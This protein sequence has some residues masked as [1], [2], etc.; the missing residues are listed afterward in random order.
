VRSLF[1]FNTFELNHSSCWEGSIL[2]YWELQTMV[3]YGEF[4]FVED[5]KEFVDE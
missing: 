2:G 5:F 3:I 4:G 1:K